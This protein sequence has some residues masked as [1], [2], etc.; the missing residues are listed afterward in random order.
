MKVIFHK[1][2]AKQLGKYPDKV[3]DTFQKRIEIFLNNPFD[4]SL[5]NH[6]LTGRWMGFRSIN[7][8]GDLRAVY[9]LVDR[10]TAYFVAFGTHSQL[11]G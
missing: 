10:E 9:E 3:H 4:P 7:I 8:S 11:Y 2:F 1:K 5:S 6:P